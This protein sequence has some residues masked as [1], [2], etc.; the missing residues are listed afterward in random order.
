M[1]LTVDTNI[2]LAVALD[3]PEKDRIIDLGLGFN[4]I[5][6]EILPYEIGNALSAMVKRRQL[7]KHEA[8]AAFDITQDIPV[9][10]VGC[11]IGK[12]LDIAMR[13]GL[14]A[15]DAYF[16]QCAQSMDS[17]LLTL[18]K[19]MQSVAKEMQITVLDPS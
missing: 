12:A 17:P 1:N 9:R 15:Y 2:F 14:Y 16:L 11:D 10:L 4:A 8:T 5:S 18:D 13:F 3:E 7:S 19:R 6:P